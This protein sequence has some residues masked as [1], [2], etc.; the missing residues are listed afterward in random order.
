MKR[1]L[2][3][4]VLLFALAVVAA[5]GGEQPA[6]AA[7]TPAPAAATPAPAATQDEP[8]PTQDEFRVA[9]L[10][11]SRGFEFMVA[12]DQGIQDKAAELGITIVVLDGNSNSEVQI[13]QIQDN[14][15][16]GVDAIILAPNNSAEL[17]AGVAL[18]NAAGVPV[19]T[20]DGIVYEGAT[21]AT[22]VSF[23]NYAGGR[24]AALTIQRLLPGGGEVLELTGAAGFYH[25]VQRGG[26]FNSGMA[27][28]N[29]TVHTRDA[30]W[31]AENAQNIVVDTVTAN[32]NINAIMTHNDEMIRGVVAGLRQIGRLVPEGQDGHIVIVGVD[33]TPIALD[34][35]RGG[36]ISATVQQDP[37]EMGARSVEL[38]YRVLTN[39]SV[40]PHYYVPE[41]VLD[42]SNVDDPTNW[43][44]MMQ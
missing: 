18:A 7:A 28:S 27:G 8:E 23:D 20:V 3:I 29:F 2:I 35:I 44:N 33:G 5:C 13:G 42:A 15:A 21:V 38:T 40:G 11:W 14:L 39:Q 36:E 30:Q 43:G 6:P 16:L 4:C 41:L 19:I 37:F 22:G 1:I 34:L 10:L 32:P 26:G 17:I 9:A 25:A 31:S 12:L 24:A